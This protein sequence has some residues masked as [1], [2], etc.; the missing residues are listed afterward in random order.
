[1][2]R[3]GDSNGSNAQARSTAGRR[4]AGGRACA[5]GPRRGHNVGM[6]DDEQRERPVRDDETGAEGQGSKDVPPAAPS[7][8]DDSALGDTDQHSSADA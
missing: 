4:D 8:D 3:A 2:T 6:T 5:A 1:M 7:S